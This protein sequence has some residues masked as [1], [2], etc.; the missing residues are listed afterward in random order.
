MIGW[1]DASSGASGDMLLAATLDAGASEEAVRAA[2]SAVSPESITLTTEQ[3]SRGGLRARRAHVSAPD[4]TTH[5]G[6]SD[7]S[8]LLE[9]AP[10]DAG[11]RGHA[12]SVFT[13]LAT[14]E[15]DVHGTD[16][17]SVHFHE[18]GA[19][20][21]IAD[22][23]GVCAAMV[24]LGLDELHCGP[25]A[26]GSGSVAAAH[27]RMSVPVPAVV[28]LLRGVP[29]YAGP[30]PHEM[31]TPTGAALLRHWVT[32]WGPQPP[33]RVRATGTGAGARDLN[34]QANAL[35]LFVGDAAEEGSGP[36]PTAAVV[37]EANVD[38]LDP[39]L[40]PQVLHHLLDAGASDAWLVPILMKK[41][42]PAHTL[43]VLVAPDRTAAVRRVV[44]TETTSLGLRERAVTK[45]ELDRDTR[46]VDVDG[47]PVTVKLG[48][49]DGQ[50]VNAQP[51]YDDVARAARLLGRPEK[52]LL[53]DAVAAAHASVPT[54]R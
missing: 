39:R 23:V 13:V 45:R 24:D 6:L 18:V 43:S 46:T 4:S 11:V 5:R 48:Y 35:R 16:P 31:C 50:L 27:G 37:L 30:V 29:T 2:V 21:A 38:D 20:D 25:V 52:V 51:E 44:F 10:I 14:A 28:S 17:D 53:A 3:V 41:G 7:I 34:G 8:A 9:A 15:A 54:A 19:L 26:V 33:M 47:Q 40:W 32:A 42:R 1:V 36:D 22:I 12:T 49:L